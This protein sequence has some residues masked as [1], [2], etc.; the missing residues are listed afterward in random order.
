MLQF[1]IPQNK[2]SIAQ[3]LKGREGNTFFKGAK[4]ALGWVGYLFY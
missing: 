4:Y 1:K 3:R 2:I